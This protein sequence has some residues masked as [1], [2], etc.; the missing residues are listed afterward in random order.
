MRNSHSFSSEIFTGRQ[1][2]HCYDGTKDMAFD[3]TA[4]GRSEDERGIG[5]RA[6]PAP[7]ITWRP[8]RAAALVLA[9]TL[10]L[11]LGGCIG[12]DG[13]VTHGY[14]LDQRSL[15]QIKVGSS[16]EQVLVVM[17]Y[18]STTSTVGGDAW[19]FITQVTDAP[20][21]FMKPR[22]TDQHVLAIYFDKEKKVQRVANYGIKDGQVFD[23]VSRT[24]PTG[25]SEG[26]FLNNIF[27]NMLHFG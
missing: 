7:A 1:A 5:T 17:G 8:A 18:P 12:Y 15:D 25:G 27:K 13:E 24:T 6:R 20:V 26:V 14:Q 22:L 4:R 21:R 23:F 3:S 19:Y 11:S 16:A 2:R 10:A 9:S